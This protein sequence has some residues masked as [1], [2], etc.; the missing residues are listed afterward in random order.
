MYLV[1][2]TGIFI[3]LTGVEHYTQPTPNQSVLQ[4]KF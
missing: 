3:D 4:K 1:Y 2:M